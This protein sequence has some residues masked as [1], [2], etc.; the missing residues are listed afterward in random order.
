[1]L[2]ARPSGVGEGPLAL[3]YRAAT[4]RHNLSF[5]SV[6]VYNQLLYYLR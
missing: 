5:T 3:T 2:V 1:M 4:V 6:I